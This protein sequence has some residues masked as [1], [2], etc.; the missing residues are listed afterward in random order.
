MKVHNHDIDPS[1]REFRLPD[2]SLRGA[3]MKPIIRYSQ[4]WWR[5]YL[6]GNPDNVA[7]YTSWVRALEYANQ[8]AQKANTK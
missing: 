6:P 7:V 5:V 2:G 4:R 3:C 1:C 8:I